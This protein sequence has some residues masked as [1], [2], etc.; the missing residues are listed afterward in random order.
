MPKTV[1]NSHQLHYI[2]RGTGIPIVF[3]HPPVLTS[4]SFIYPIEQLSP[5][6]RTI[7]LDIRGHGQSEPSSEALTYPLIVQDIKAL[8]Q[9]LN[10]DQAFFCGY[11]TGGS[12]MLEY[13]LTYPNDVLGGIMISGMSEAGD[14]LLRGLISLGY[15]FTKFKAF[16]T[17]AFAVSWAQAQTK[18]NLIRS[19]YDDARQGDAKNAEQYYH[20]SLQYNCTARLSTIQQPM[21]LIYG[22]KDKRFHRYANLLH[23]H[24]PN[25]ELMFIEH[26]SHQIPTKA[27]GRLNGLI[28]QF[29]DQCDQ[30]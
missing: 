17:V 22:E 4:T 25:N 24:L 9:Q 21:L 16:K 28:K 8:L 30:H 5:H 1:I 2:D 12:V 14:K 11:S 29:I 19:L 7:A 6:Y 15:L 27:A 13:M 10:I 20:Y 23:Q 18:P 3:I 26:I